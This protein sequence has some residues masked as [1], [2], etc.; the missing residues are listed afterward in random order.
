MIELIVLTMLARPTPIL[1]DWELM[2]RAQTR[3]EYLCEHDQ[4]SHDGWKDSFEGIAGV[5][6]ENL[7]KDFTS[8][9]KA[10]AALMDSPTHKQNILD[11]EFH[12]IGVGKSCGI[13]VQ[14]FST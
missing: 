5:H 6:G 3:A 11:P 2:A 12:S 8:V 7:A 9:K 13:Y 14:L 10:H 1:I 4:W